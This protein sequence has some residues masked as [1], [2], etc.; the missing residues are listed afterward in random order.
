MA[1]NI[2]VTFAMLSSLSIYLFDC[3]PLIDLCLEWLLLLLL[4]LQLQLQLLLLVMVTNSGLRLFD[5]SHSDCRSFD[6]VVDCETC[7]VSLFKYVTSRS[8]T[9]TKLTPQPSFLTMRLT[10]EF[11]E[12]IAFDTIPGTN[13]A[14][15]AT[16]SSVGQRRRNIPKISY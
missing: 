10:N 14:R 7:C 6:M 15:C 2:S 11:P 8:D 16:F 1:K 3:H 12:S 4:W 5:N 13:S 9:N